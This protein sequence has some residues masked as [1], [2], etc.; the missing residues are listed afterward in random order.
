MNAL[1]NISPNQNSTLEKDLFLCY[2]YSIEVKNDETFNSTKK[3][4][5]SYMHYLCFD[6]S[7]NISFL[8]AGRRLS[9]DELSQEQ[10]PS[11]FLCLISCLRRSHA[12]KGLNFLSG[13]I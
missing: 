5:F 10:S 13:L 12:L 8:S 4:D 6:F 11:L 2:D 9:S 3:V 1:S 7:K